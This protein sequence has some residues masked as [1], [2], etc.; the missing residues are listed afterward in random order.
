MTTASS[1]SLFARLDDASDEM[2]R[3][4]IGYLDAVAMHQEMQRVRT[5]AFELFGPSPGERL[6]DAGCG[7]GEVARQLAARV[8]AGGSVVAVDQ[9]V[10]AISIAQSRHDGS[11]VTYVVGD[12]TALDF[13]D[14]HFDGVRSERVLQHLSDPDG[15]IE[16][17]RRVT[18][19]G[20]RVCVLDTDW[21]SFVSDGFDHLD[22]VVAEFFRSHRL[23]R[24][25]RDRPAGR[26]VRSRMVKA[27]LQETIVLP[28]TL[29]FTALE[30]AAIVSPLFN[31][32]LLQDGLPAE[33]LERFFASV[34]RSV[35]RGDFLFAF[36]MW[37]S[38]GRVP[39]A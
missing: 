35:D 30:D 32:S 31:R 9:S 22:D 5:A 28:V 27:G 18:R 37:I 11:P 29:R 20:G 7:A 4:A 39:H 2:Q 33:L 15:A 26:T 13:P 24:S 16:E 10:Q 21:A 8:G 19:P 1:G 36:T 38:M 3:H 25:Y 17:L 6:L 23:F 34:H 12:I 14:G